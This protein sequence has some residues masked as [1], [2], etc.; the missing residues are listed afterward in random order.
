MGCMDAVGSTLFIH[1]EGN[2]KVKLEEGQIREI[3]L[4][5]RFIVKM[6]VDATEPFEAPPAGSIFLKVWYD[7][8]LVTAHN[9]VGDP[10]LAINEQA[11]LASN[12]KREL[13][14]GLGK[15]RRDQKGRGGSAT[16]QVVEAADLICL[17]SACLS[18]NLN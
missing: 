1:R 18:L 7:N 10:S 16:I 6:G 9:D 11:D 17:E 15:F 4:G 12:F 2:H 14:D 3:I 5:K 13:A 8:P